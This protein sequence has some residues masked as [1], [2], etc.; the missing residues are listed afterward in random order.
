LVWVSGRER[1]RIT[2]GEELRYKVRERYA[3]AARSVR[4]GS[5]ASDSEAPDV[6]WTGGSYSATEVG[7][8]PQ[9]AIDASL[10]CGIPVALATLSPGEVV[11]DL[12]RAGL[13]REERRGRW[14]F[15]SLD[16]EAAG[17]LLVEVA[18][19]LGVTGEDG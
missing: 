4:S 13:V 2:M 11:L 6:D 14:S 7:E 1:R 19:H 17:C 9:A 10:G 12:G 15:Y 3:E 16:R 5:R 18:D 8:L